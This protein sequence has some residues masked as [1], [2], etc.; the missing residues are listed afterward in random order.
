MIVSTF[1]FQIIYNLH[2]H[3]NTSLSDLDVD[4]EQ[5]ERRD[6]TKA[7]V[8]GGD[9]S[10]DVVLSRHD[11]PRFYKRDLLPILGERN[12]LDISQFCGLLLLPTNKHRREGSFAYVAK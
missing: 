10:E 11:K 4:R 6:V 5:M 9:E 3:E 2:Y 12:H 7:S 1:H 8:Q